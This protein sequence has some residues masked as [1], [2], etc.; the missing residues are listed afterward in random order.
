[1]IVELESLHDQVLA[2]SNSSHLGHSDVGP[3]PAAAHF[4]C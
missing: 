1:M 3:D 4:G 2:L